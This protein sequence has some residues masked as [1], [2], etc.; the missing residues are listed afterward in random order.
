[1]IQFEDHSVDGAYITLMCTLP[2][3]KYWY[4]NSSPSKFIIMKRVTLIDGI[5]MSFEDAILWDRN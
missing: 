4:L 5:L 1:M 2:V 3:Y